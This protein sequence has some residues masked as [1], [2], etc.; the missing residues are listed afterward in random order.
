MKKIRLILLF[1]LIP[2]I[3]GTTMVNAQ[4]S[5][6]KGKQKGKQE[7]GKVAPEGVSS[8]TSEPSPEVPLVDEKLP[9]VAPPGSEIAKPEVASPPPQKEIAKPEPSPKSPKAE[10][11]APEE[12]K[13][14]TTGI[15][16]EKARN[17]FQPAFFGPPPPKQTKETVKTPKKTGE[18]A[19]RKRIPQLKG[20]MMGEDKSALAILDNKFVKEGDEIGGFRVKKITTNEIVLDC[21]GEEVTLYVKK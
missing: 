14:E 13:K 11:P 17:I 7:S 16:W 3:L 8:G 4:K 10:S 2:L 18:P 21:D 20:I 9:E 1:F 12:I 19:V 5:H 6:V 15:N